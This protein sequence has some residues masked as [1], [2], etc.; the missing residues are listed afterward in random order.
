MELT[1]TQQ[2]KTEIHELRES[3]HELS[4]ASVLQKTEVSAQRGDIQ[5]L[6]KAVF[7]IAKSMNEFMQ[8]AREKGIENSKDFQ[9]VVRHVNEIHDNVEQLESSVRSVHDKGIYFSGAIFIIGFLVTAMMSLA[10]GYVRDIVGMETRISILESENKKM[11]AVIENLSKRGGAS[12]QISCKENCPP[13]APEPVP[14]EL[15]PDADII[16]TRL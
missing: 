7:A 12:L 9:A 11:S 16:V 1:D 3:V 10:P 2:I 4:E 13:P 8:A 5:E 15:P 6:T 14:P